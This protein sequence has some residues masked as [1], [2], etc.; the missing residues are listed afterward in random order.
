M[1]IDMHQAIIGLGD[2]LTRQMQLG[3]EVHFSEEVFVILGCGEIVV[4]GFAIVHV[5]LARLHRLV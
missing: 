3:A 4:E 1:H 5:C 2:W